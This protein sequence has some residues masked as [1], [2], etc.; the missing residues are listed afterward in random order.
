MKYKEN[1]I[2]IG[3]FKRKFDFNIRKVVETR[4]YFVILLSIPFDNNSIDNIYGID[5]SSL[6]LWRVE[7]NNEWSGLPYEN[8]NI[9]TDG[10]IFATDFYGRGV[11]IDSENGRILDR[12][13]TK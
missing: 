1:T 5:E 10:N 8:M 2:T 3:D 6:K 4:G 11:L 9:T 7:R 13:I 12:K